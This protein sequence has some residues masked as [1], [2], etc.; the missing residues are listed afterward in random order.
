ML[1]RRNEERGRGR[2]REVQIAT[3]DTAIFDFYVDVVGVEGFGREFV[4]F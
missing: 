4:E 3:A 1:A 2:G